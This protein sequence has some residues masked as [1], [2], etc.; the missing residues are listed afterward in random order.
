MRILRN[1]DGIV[2]VTTMM[3]SL[4]ALMIT[5]VMVYMVLQNTK[6]SGTSR[7][8]RNSLEAATGAVEIVT[9]EAIPDLIQIAT[10]FNDSGVPGSP[11]FAAG[12]A[13]SMNFTGMDLAI[14]DAACLNAKLTQKTWGASCSA[15]NLTLDAKQAPDMAFNLNSQITAGATGYR[16][17]TKIVSTTPGSSDLSGR[18]LEGQAVTGAPPQDVGAPYLYRLEVAGERISNPKERADLSVLYAY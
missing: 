13:A 12:L 5:M 1:E 14:P 16:V 2:L 4:I 9:K 15:A 18:E 3:L 7:Q 8:Y 10:N 17:Y 6:L 11:D